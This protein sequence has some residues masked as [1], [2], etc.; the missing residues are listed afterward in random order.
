MAEGF[1]KKWLSLRHGVG[2]QDLEQHCGIRVQSRGQT[3]LDVFALEV[4]WPLP[5]G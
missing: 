4:F 5:R 3:F 1:A 2:P